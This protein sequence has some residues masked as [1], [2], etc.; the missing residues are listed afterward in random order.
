MTMSV[1]MKMATTRDR[2]NGKSSYQRRLF[3]GEELE[4][5]EGGSKLEPKLT[6]WMKTGDR[7]TW[8]S[9]GWTAGRQGDK[10]TGRQG[11]RVT[12]N[13]QEEDYE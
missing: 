5:R 3:I 1:T 2:P 7:V 4:R 13:G 11:E 6:T 12:E 9:G 8:W 10:A